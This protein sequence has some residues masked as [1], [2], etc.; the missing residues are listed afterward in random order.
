MNLG[1]LCLFL[2]F[3]LIFKSIFKCFSLFKSRKRGG[4][5]TAGDDVASGPRRRVDLACG[6]A[7][8]CDMALRPRGRATAGPRGAQVALTRVPGGH[9][10]ESMWA[11]VWGAT[12]QV[13]WQMEGPRS[14]GLWLV[15]WGGNANALPRTPI[16]MR[17]LP[18][19][20]PCGTMFPHVLPV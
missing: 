9:A 14:S 12:W 4:E 20:S 13:G 16:Y 5:L 6:S 10:D 2:I 8:G 18:I 3:Y 19:F 1:S 15:I 17:Y 11:P 7:R